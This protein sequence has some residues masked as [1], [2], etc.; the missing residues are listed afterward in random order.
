MPEAPTL[1]VRR[2]VLAYIVREAPALNQRSVVIF[3]FCNSNER[4]HHLLAYAFGAYVVA[5]ESI[6][7]KQLLCV[8][9]PVEFLKHFLLHFIL[10]E[11]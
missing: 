9:S 8:E 5:P 2:V 7:Q 10:K 4:H 11:F 6:C 3:C 1:R